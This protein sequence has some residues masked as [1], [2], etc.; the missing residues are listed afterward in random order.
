MW[1]PGRGSADCITG[2]A[3]GSRPSFA[4][5][6]RSCHRPVHSTGRPTLAVHA[7]GV[8]GARRLRP[9]SADLRAHPAEPPACATGHRRADV[10]ADGVFTTH[11]PEL[12]VLRSLARVHVPTA[13][14]P[15]L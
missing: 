11:T 15:L 1:S 6:S 10:L 9:S 8:D 2:T 7:P 5:Q 13:H 12:T 3:D 4:S 14:A